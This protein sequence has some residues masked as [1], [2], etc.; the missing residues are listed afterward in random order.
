MMDIVD[1]DFCSSLIIDNLAD[2]IANDE[3]GKLKEHVIKRYKHRAAIH[4]Y[5][6]EQLVMT[7]ELLKRLAAVLRIE[8]DK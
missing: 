1:I 4:D 6:I 3:S 2:K 5:L 8:G 7:E